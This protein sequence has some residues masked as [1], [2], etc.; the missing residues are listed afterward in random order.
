MTKQIKPINFRPNVLEDL[1]LE[2][3]ASSDLPIKKTKSELV[4]YCIKLAG[5]QLIEEEEFKE[6]LLYSARIN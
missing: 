4:R 2:K 1:I 5:E 6:L 3:L